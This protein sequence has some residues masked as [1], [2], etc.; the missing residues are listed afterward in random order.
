[1][2]IKKIE[3]QWKEKLKQYEIQKEQELRELRLQREDEKKKSHVIEE[4]KRR[5]LAE[6]AAVLKKFYPKGYGKIIG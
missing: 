2:Y 3:L 6:N 5:L 1:M 4:E